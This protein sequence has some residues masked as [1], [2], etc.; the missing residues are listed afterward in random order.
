MPRHSRSCCSTSCRCS[1]VSAPTIFKRLGSLLTE[2]S[3]SSGPEILISLPETYEL[4]R[5]LEELTAPII[6]SG[7]DLYSH[8]DSLAHVVG[9][10]I[11]TGDAKEKAAR[12]QKAMK[13]L[14]V[15]RASLARR[16]KFLRSTRGTRG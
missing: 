8:L 16:V 1:R 12:T 14:E 6:K 3:I 15:V 5:I 13:Q 11:V 7:K 4:L 2:S 10:P 9:G